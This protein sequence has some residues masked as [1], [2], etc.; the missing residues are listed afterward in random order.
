MCISCKCRYFSSLG[1][2]SLEI[3]NAVLG[4]HFKQPTVEFVEDVFLSRQRAIDEVDQ[5]RWEKLC[6]DLMQS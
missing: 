4:L 1:K 3:F 2:R 6:P 5:S